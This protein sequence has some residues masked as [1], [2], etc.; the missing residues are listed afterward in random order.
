MATAEE[1][2][3]LMAANKFS[4]GVQLRQMQFRKRLV[5][6]WGISAGMRVLE[7]GCGQGDTTAALADAV[8]ESGHVCA[9]DLAGPLYGSPVTLG[10]STQHLLRG[11]LGSRIDFHL[12][13]DLLAPENNFSENEF[14]AIVLSHCT[15]YFKSLDQLKETFTR[16]RAWAP[17]LCLSE[18]DL[19]PQSK[20]QMA[21]LLA[22]LIQGQVEAFKT[23]SVANV[24][25]P[26]S[27]DTLKT[28]LV[29]TGWEV[30]LETI[31]ETTGLDDARWEIDAC[32]TNSLTEGQRL[33]LPAKILELVSSQTDVLRNLAATGV[34][35]PLPSYSIVAIQAET[36]MW[37]L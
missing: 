6:N 15:W 7:I 23:E 5:E 27:R 19:E 10:D 33:G 29:Q 14:D 21:H 9:V 8:G 32:L 16:I 11:P 4:P 34:V 25:T 37:A 12:Q 35:Q 30:V 1:L 28:L 2:G 22:I 24:R 18:W 20:H 31:L 17:R 36:G 3:S 13:F 26:Y